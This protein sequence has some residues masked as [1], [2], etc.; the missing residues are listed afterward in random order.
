[1]NWES[2]NEMHDFYT[3]LAR[4]INAG[5]SNSVVVSGNV[6]DLFWNDTAYVPLVPF[7]LEKT[8][9]SNRIQ[10]VYELNGPL[11]VA[12]EE[13]ARLATAWTSWRKSLA[14]SPKKPTLASVTQH[15]WNGDQDPAAEFNNHMATAMQ[16]SVFALEFLRQ[17]CFCSREI[18]KETDLLIFIEAADLLVPAG[19]GDVANLSEA[20]LRRI[21]I[22]Q[23]W[24]S[25]PAFLDS[26][27]A[28]CLVAES[29]A[30]I[31]PRISRLPQ[32]LEVEVPSPDFEV[33]RHFISQYCGKQTKCPTCHQSVHDSD[34][35]GTL[36]WTEAEQQWA[37]TM[38]A[39]LSVHALRQLMAEAVYLRQPLSV[40]T[41]SKAVEGFI[42]VQVGDDVVEFSRP[43]HKLDAVIGA[44][45][46]VKFL[47]SELIPSMQRGKLSGCAVAGPIGGGKTFVFE[48]VAA[49]LDMPVLVLKNLRS[50]WFGQTDV[51][52]ER[53]RRALESLDKVCIFMDEADTQF[54]G[55]GVG[56]HETERRLT[57]KIQAM[58]S[59]PRLKGRVIWLLMTARIHLLSPDIRRPGRAGDMIVPV[60]DPQ[61]QDRLEFIRWSLCPIAEKLG[62]ELADTIQSLDSQL[63]SDYSA[64]AFASLRNYLESQ[65]EGFKMVK[66][67]EVIA[68][69]GE[70]IPPNI[71]TTRR[72]QTL[73][74]LVNCTRRSLIETSSTLP[75]KREEWMREIAIL[76]RR[77]VQ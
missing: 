63:D 35:P 56:T 38:T 5:Q 73:H 64:A 58:M 2:F 12:P 70:L 20:S 14:S 1:M 53:L 19:N 13:R 17:L 59:D 66:K 40:E 4:I 72:L 68:A 62:R 43:H 6:Y 11:R 77:G 76:E 29:R 10:I 39:S 46:L 49:E 26:R 25:D 67:E 36:N 55:V 65:F 50:Q 41:I 3:R 27:D 32:I 42:R 24:F 33:R 61:G 44:S 45:R 23:D 18:I 31:H 69:V 8:A 16:N 21:S 47:R 37:A 22:L 54:G 9:P 71:G 30:L 57:G 60:L 7:L 52:F 15:L 28:V 75:A 34:C 48:A 51:I 74:A